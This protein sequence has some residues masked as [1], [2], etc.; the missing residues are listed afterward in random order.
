MYIVEVGNGHKF[1]GP[2]A[3]R[4]AAQNWAD[5]NGFGGRY[6]GYSMTVALVVAP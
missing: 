4:T 2:F 5:E 6:S 1:V 3:S